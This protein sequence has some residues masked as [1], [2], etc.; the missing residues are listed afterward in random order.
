MSYMKLPIGIQSFS[1]IITGGYVYVDKTSYLVDLVKSGKFYFL[2]RPRRFGKSLLVDTFDCAFSSRRDLFSGLYLDSYKSGW[3]WNRKSPVLKIDWSLYP[4]RTEEGLIERI[5]ELLTSWAEQWSIDLSETTI[6]GQFDRVVREIHIKTGEQVVILVDE[7][8]K[9]IL[10]ALENSTRAS[11]MRDILR[12]FYGVIKPLDPHI[13]FVLLTGVSKFVKTGIFSGLNN[14]KD[15]TLDQRYSAICGYTDKD[16]ETVFSSWSLGKD[17]NQMKKWYNGYSWTGERVY[18][19]FDILLYF[20]SGIFKP[21]WFETGTP[22]FLLKLWKERPELPADYDGL[23]VGDDILGSFDPEHIRLETLLFQ[24]GYLTVKSWTSDSVRGFRCVLGYP[25]KEVRISLNLLFS[26]Y[27]NGQR[28]TETRDKLYFI[29]ESGDSQGLKELFHSFF[30]SIPHD[31]YRKN[32]ISGFEGYWASIVYTYFAS[33]GYDLI[34]EDTTNKGRIDLTVKT[35]SGIW[36]FEFKVKGIDKSGDE[37]PL[38]Q[39]KKR[40]YADKYQ[41]DKRK[42]HEIGVVF[43]PITRNIDKWSTDLLP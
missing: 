35:E 18:N 15:I 20:D 22:S 40:G 33:L 25:N 7:Y 43:D 34:P 2:S 10:D 14:L 3:N 36:I 28:I 9:P 39:I 16:L 37:D 12:D 1:E 5:H 24:A 11:A 41:S 38:N 13:R 21:Y 17:T 19:P 6:G 27:L 31:W 32:Q 26:E 4:P 8:D 29:L 23:V 42:I 30:A